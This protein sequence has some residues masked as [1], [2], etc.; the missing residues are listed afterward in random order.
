M[1]IGA[2]PFR[3]SHPDAFIVRRLD[4]PAPSACEQRPEIP[5]RIEAAVRKAL[6]WKPEERFATAEELRDEL[7]VGGSGPP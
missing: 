2:P 6:E 5:K 1:L 4:D 3:P 7:T